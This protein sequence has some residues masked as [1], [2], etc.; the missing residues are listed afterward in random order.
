MDALVN[1]YPGL[2]VGGFLIV[3]DYGHG[4]CKEAVTQFRDEHGI[5]EPIEQVDWLGAF[6]RREH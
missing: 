1:L 3:D 6:W 4:P 5:G 2:S